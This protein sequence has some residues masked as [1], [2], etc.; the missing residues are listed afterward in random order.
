[1]TSKSVRRVRRVRDDA[2]IGST[3]KTVAN[4]TGLPAAS[5]RIVLPSGRK[6]HADA[7]LG[8]L[9]RKWQK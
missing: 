7:P 3:V 4:L 1:M 5:I 6:A 9:K 8:N 2:T